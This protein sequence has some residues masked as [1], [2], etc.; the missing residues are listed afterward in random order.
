[1][2]GAVAVNVIAPLAPDSVSTATGVLVAVAS[3]AVSL[4]AGVLVAVASASASPAAGVVG[5]SAV[6][7]AD[8]VLVAA[9]SAAGVPVAGLSAITPFWTVTGAE[10]DVVEPSSPSAPTVTVTAPVTGISTVAVH[11]PLASTSASPV[12]APS[13]TI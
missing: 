9:T 6:S 11:V 13:T 12:G 3:D 4:A 8:G 10:D 5:S 1:M 2:L 7:V